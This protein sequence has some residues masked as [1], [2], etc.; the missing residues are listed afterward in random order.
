MTRIEIGANSGI[1]RVLSHSERE[2]LEY[3]QRFLTRRRKDR[4]E[5]VLRQRTRCLQVVLE[6]VYQPHNQSAVL[7][8]AEALGLQDV[9]IIEVE[10][11]LKI[12]RDISL[13]SERW[14]TL[15]RHRGEDQP[16]AC[17]Q[18]LHD[19]GFQL[20]A[21]S[22]DADA[23]PLSEVTMEQPTVLVVGHE[24]H[25]ISEAARKLMQGRIHV[26][27]SGFVE[28]LN[29]SVAAAVCLV[30]LR[31]QLDGSTLAWGL[32][33]AEQQELRLE[34]TRRSISHVEAIERRYWQ[35]AASNLTGR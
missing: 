21:A 23:T 18:R 24:V 29:L 16:Q 33:E 31:T 2:I 6:D 5:E 30:H 15:H 14:L 13:G 22:S 35:D 32:T 1:L 8:S 7:R 12:A 9:H 26:P 28:S 4:F 34:W 19:Q 25:G 20:L 10:N 3:L 11:R 27:M 17:L